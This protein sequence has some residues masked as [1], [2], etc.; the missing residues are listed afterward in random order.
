MN[1]TFYNRT[2]PEAKASDG[3]P[4]LTPRQRLERFRQLTKRGQKVDKTRCQKV[5][6]S[7]NPGEPEKNKRS[8]LGSGTGST[9]PNDLSRIQNGPGQYK[10][11]NFDPDI[12][13]IISTQMQHIA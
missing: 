11:K 12:L 8:Y 7:Q 1:R 6:I 9:L 10:N 2:E 4:V 5:K 3:S 13:R